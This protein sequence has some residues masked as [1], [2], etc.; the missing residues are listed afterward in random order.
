MRGAAV[1][2]RQCAWLPALSLR[3]FG[4]RA[5]GL[6]ALALL[7]LGLLAN[8]HARAGALNALG[9]RFWEWRAATQP[10]GA[11]DIPRIERPAGLVIDWSAAAVAQRI[12]TLDSFEGEWR[13]L[14]PGS[15]APDAQ[16][17]VHD[18][19][20][21]RLLGAAIARV[22]WELSVVQRW[23]R[24]P[25]FYVEETLGSLVIDLLPPAPFDAARRREIVARVRQMP[26]TLSAARR[27]LTDIRR[28]FAKLTMDALDDI[29]H[30]LRQSAMALAPVFTPTDHRRLLAALPAAITALQDY[31]G[32][33]ATQMPNARDETAIGREAY[34]YFLRN[35]ALLPF[36]PE[37]LLAMSRQEWSRAVAFEAYQ[38][39]R[40]GPAAAVIFADS[41]AQIAAAAQAE[42]RIRDFLVDRKILSVP[43]WLRHYRDLPIPAYL[44]PLQDF[45]E[46]DDLTGPS[47]LDQDATR[48]IPVPRAGLGFFSLSSA[49][50]PRPIIVHEGV[51]GH[52]F[53]LCLGWR[54]KDP[55]R[56][57]Y[58]DSTV[59]EGIGF[60]AEE[61][62]LQA[63][64]FDDNPHTRETIF[65]FMR[66]RAL[67]VEVDVKLALGA[68]TLSQAADYLQQTVPMDRATASEEAARFAGTPGQAISY[69]IGKIQITELL[70]DARRAQGDAFSLQ[71]FHDFVW[72]NGNV[73]LSLQRWELLGD[74][75]A[76][77]DAVAMPV[78]P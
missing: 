53:Q 61:M 77:P 20:D 71:Q 24:D 17:S 75:S 5:F 4:L 33:L 31:R 76:V 9:A 30:R 19:V 56:R 70:A 13:S 23:K 72:N 69:Q 67:R 18:Q 49:R 51:P 12:R 28:P 48:Y 45:G 57:H 7:A 32:W 55:L 21:F 64:L 43:Q 74:A 10:F 27:N 11:D 66:L 73:P 46:A 68:F 35:V 59:N 8:G 40:S 15:A 3:A 26:G 36:T 29:A 41:D 34:V 1:N 58:V 47:R 37:Q 54:N 42:L 62:M 14:A 60:Y 16:T 22:R 52:Y 2:R 50:D 25:S 63:G 44:E 6:F 65:S 38:Q 78:Q 39:A